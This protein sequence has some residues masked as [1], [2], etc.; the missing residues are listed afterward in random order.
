MSAKAW[1]R[2]SGVA[3]AHSSEEMKGTGEAPNGALDGLG[4]PV[5]VVGAGDEAPAEAL[6][7]LPAL[8]AALG[9]EGETPI[10]ALE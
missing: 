1:S 5:A 9:S 8:D 2:A 4:A 10:E 3:L 7:R 6:E